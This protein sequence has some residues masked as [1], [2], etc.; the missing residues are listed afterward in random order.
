M[1]LQMYLL[2][3]KME[4]EVTNTTFQRRN[5]LNHSEFITE[6]FGKTEIDFRFGSNQ[7]IALLSK[8]RKLF[9]G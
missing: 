4:A 6:R 9:N 8:Q 1:T 2:E 5:K 3:E 7:M